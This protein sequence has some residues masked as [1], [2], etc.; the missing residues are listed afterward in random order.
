MPRL[1]RKDKHYGIYTNS[2]G[3]SF[4]AYMLWNDKKGG[5]VLYSGD[6]D[7]VLTNTAFSSLAEMKASGVK[8]HYV[9]QGT[10]QAQPMETVA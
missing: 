8:F 6:T 3:A 4:G 2:R 9:A 10:A 1:S 7:R 5:F